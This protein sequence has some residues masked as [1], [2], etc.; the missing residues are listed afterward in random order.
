MQD[1]FEIIKQQ[2]PKAREH[3]E[4]LED[5]YKLSINLAADVHG[6]MRMRHVLEDEYLRSINL[7]DFIRR[8]WQGG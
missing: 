3:Y 8:P 6:Q 1:S 4:V 7:A 5:D 2:M